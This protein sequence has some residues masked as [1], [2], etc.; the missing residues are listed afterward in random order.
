MY[1]ST[2]AKS[3]CIREKRPDRYRLKH[4]Q[5]FFSQR[6]VPFY[7]FLCFLIFFF[8]MNL[9]SYNLKNNEAFFFTSLSLCVFFITHR[10]TGG[11]PALYIYLVTQIVK[12]LP[13]V[14]ETWIRSWVG[15]ISWRRAW[16]PT[17]VFLPGES[18][19]GGAWWATVHGVSKSRTQLSD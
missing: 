13:A 12:S 14:Q 11:T 19:D 9:Y 7:T 18:V 17:P 1:D 5:Q 3:M 6:N 8:A 2:F 15:K 10:P 4:W 16:Q